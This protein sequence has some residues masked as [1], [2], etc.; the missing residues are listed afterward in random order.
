MVFYE[1]ARARR[2]QTG[3]AG[4]GIDRGRAVAGGVIFGLREA[5]F[6]VLYSQHSAVGVVGHGR[7]QCARPARRGQRGCPRKLIAVG[8]IRVFGDVPCRI[9]LLLEAAGAVVDKGSRVVA[10]ERD[11]SRLPDPS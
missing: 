4:Q 2:K 10:G 7:H 1:L 8:V 3:S 5:A 6:G 11:G 9:G